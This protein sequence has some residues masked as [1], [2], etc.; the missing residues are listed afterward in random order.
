MKGKNAAIGF[1]FVTILIDVI[2][3]G[4]IIPVMP[5]LISTMINGTTSEAATYGGWLLFAYAIMQ[6]IFS[7]IIAEYWLVIY[8]KINCRNYRSK[9]YNRNSLYC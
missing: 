8:W 3:F 6:F 2:G 7:P 1:I 9:F 5:K 4:I